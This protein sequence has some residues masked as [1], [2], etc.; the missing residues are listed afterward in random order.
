MMVLSFVLTS[1]ISE[2]G[3]RN[4]LLILGAGILA[5]GWL[6]ALPLR[7]PRASEQGRRSTADTAKEKEAPT[8]ETLLSR[9]L[10]LPQ[11]PVREAEA[12]LA[13]LS[14]P[15]SNGNV[16]ETRL[17]PATSSMEKLPLEGASDNRSNW[18]Q[19]LRLPNTW[20]YGLAVVLAN[21]AYTFSV[22]NIVSIM[23]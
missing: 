19:L 3:W 10:A 23:A 6:A 17:V 18:C 1:L 11:S 21:N 7:E 9:P 14:K 5:L 22:I 15:D 13:G 20:L 12:R 2:F 4:C 8:R 16:V